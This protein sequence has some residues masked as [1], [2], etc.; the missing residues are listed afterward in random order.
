MVFNVPDYNFHRSKRKIGH[1]VA[2]VRERRRET[3]LVTKAG[4]LAR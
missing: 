1:R 4:R 2:R 3:Q